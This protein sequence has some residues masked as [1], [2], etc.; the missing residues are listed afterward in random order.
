MKRPI[1]LNID[2]HTALVHVYREHSSGF[3]KDGRPLSP[4]VPYEFLTY[5]CDV[6]EKYGLC[7]KLSFVPEP[8]CRGDIVH[9]LEG[10][11][12]EALEQWKKTV[13][14]R[15]PGF[16]LGAEM[17]THHHALN[18]LTGTWRDENEDSWSRRQTRG[19]MTPYIAHALRL[20]KEAGIP[21]TGVT[22]PWMFGSTV[23]EE[24]RAAIA[25][26]MRDVF[27]VNQAWY[28]TWTKQEYPTICEPIPGFRLASVY[29]STHDQLW[30]A[31]E[32]PR[33]DEAYVDQL[34]D[35]YLTADGQ[36][37]A[38]VEILKKDAPV[39]ITAH[40]QTLYSNGTWCGARAI[41]RIAQRVEKLLP[42]LEWTP[43][44]KLA[45]ME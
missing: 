37:G 38:I 7:G 15:L 8:G 11:T 44:T 35:L 27:G 45:G 30:K 36:S 22:S 20:L 28:F 1:A 10:F 42:E 25:A 12:L 26:A 32:C 16:S 39:V 29:S 18:Y 2:D 5:F 4:F 14:T 31:I 9:G 23:E 34:A 33:A 24:Y 19:T 43:F 6:A 21:A 17:L 13:L 40:W 3:T 41:E